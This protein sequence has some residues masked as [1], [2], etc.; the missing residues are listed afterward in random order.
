MYG[1]P[2]MLTFTDIKNTQF[3]MMIG[4]NPAVSNTSVVQMPHPIREL[5]AIEARGGKVV[6]LNPRRIETSKAV[7]EHH[8]IRPGTDVFFLL[9]FLRE[10]LEIGAVDQDRVGRY[11]SG[12]EEVAAMVHAWTPE[13]TEKVTRVPAKTLRA[14][15][16]QYAEADGATLFCST[17]LN[18]G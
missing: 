16:R 1:S 5:K 10:L 3:L 2:F 9:S 14:L 7:G 11:M 17:G 12:L 8:F 6:F 4:A 15:A 18:Q 13:K